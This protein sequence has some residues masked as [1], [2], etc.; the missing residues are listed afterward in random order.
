MRCG[1]NGWQGIHAKTPVTQQDA[2]AWH[3][4]G[5]ADR[6]RRLK[7]GGVTLL[8]HEQGNVLESIT[9]IHSETAANHMLAVA[10]HIVSE[11]Y[12]R[13]VVVVVI[14]RLLGYE[15]SRQGAKGG[16]CLE[17]LEGAAVCNIRTPDEIP[18]LVPTE[19][20]V[21]AQATSHLPV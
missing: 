15:G 10:G 21:H 1:R 5:R 20:E 11:P 3:L 16:G 7:D 18:V 12:T 4:V 17:F 8:L 14:G 2:G 19:P 13:A 9:V 6:E